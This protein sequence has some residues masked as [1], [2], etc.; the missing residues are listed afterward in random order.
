M[1]ERFTSAARKAVV[2]AQVEARQLSHPVIGSEHL[3]LGVLDEPDGLG[4]RALR[5][6]GVNPAGVRASI[7]EIVG[8]GCGH[9][10]DAD[11][12]RSIGI[13][14]D[15]V[16]KQVE[17]AFG[18]GALDRPRGRCRRGRRRGYPPF[19]PRAKK[20]LELALREA[21]YR[22][23]GYVGTEHVLLGTLREGRGLAALILARAGI[24][25]VAVEAALAELRRTG[26]ADTG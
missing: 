11:A 13:D 18:P 26:Q 1:F 7:V 15:A 6:L 14:L 22:K 8:R 24:D 10:L 25:R 23:D 20:V 5:R 9:D 19:T 16:R 2:Q 4:G 12:L 21:I 3:L 17:G